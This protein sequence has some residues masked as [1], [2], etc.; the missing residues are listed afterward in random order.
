M[1]QTRKSINVFVDTCAFEEKI[2]DWKG[3]SLS[4]LRSLAEKGQIVLITTDITQREISARIEER[5]RKATGELKQLRP[6]I[7]V[8]KPALGGSDNP[9]FK[10]LDPEKLLAEF[11]EAQKQFFAD[12][13]SEW[14]AV[15]GHDSKLIFDDYFEP[16]PP[17]G[18][19]KKKSEFPDAFVIY[20]LRR[21]CESHNENVHVV[22]SDQ[23]VIGACADSL[24]PEPKLDDFLDRLNLAFDLSGNLEILTQLIQNQPS[25]I[26]EFLEAEFPGLGFWLDDQDGDVTDVVVQDAQIEDVLILDQ[27]DGVLSI[28]IVA[29]VSFTAE[30]DYWDPDNATYDE[31]DVI[32]YD[33]VEETIERTE[34]VRLSASCD[35]DLKAPENFQIEDLRIEEPQDVH[36]SSDRSD[37][38]RLK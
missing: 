1:S 28:D 14:I 31:G 21:W 6:K 19:G 17:F 16:K 20:A 11:A 4:S 3:R 13:R 25:T 38:M 18:H 32:Y 24:I 26:V 36:V 22:S 2:F 7:A 27:N 35:V 9:V 12:C 33:R 10:E 15:Y 29:N 30:L 8:L 5:V 23:G 34:Q 37:P